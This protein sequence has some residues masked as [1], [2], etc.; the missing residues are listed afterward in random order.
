MSD[1]PYAEKTRWLEVNVCNLGY[2]NFEGAGKYDIP[3][4]EP[5][6]IDDIE[7]IP[8]Q[9][10]NFALKDDNPQGKAVHFFL[11]DYQFER[12]WKYPDRYTDVLSRFKYVLSPDFSCFSD[13]PFAVRVFNTYRNRWCARYWQTQGLTVVPTVTWSDDETFEFCLDGL[14]KHSTIAISTMGD[15][16]YNDGEAHMKHWDEM[17]ERLEPE[18]IILYGNSKQNTKFKGNIVIKKLISSKVSL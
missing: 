7:S 10:F 13:T 5:V 6:H 3:I 18:K 4:L 11:H 17:L 12:V 15:F 16:W 14:P 9:G 2:G 8:L 1:K